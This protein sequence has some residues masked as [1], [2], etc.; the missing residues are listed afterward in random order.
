MK[1]SFY[2]PEANVRW[3]IGIYTGADWRRL[4][5]A[6]GLAHPVL[7]PE[8]VTDGRSRLVAD[9]F[10]VREEG[11]WYMFF[12]TLDPAVGRGE[13]AYATSADGLTWRYGGVVLREPFHLSY[14]RVFRWEGRY[15]M[16]P[17]TRQ[18][19]AVRL[20]TAV[21]F[22]TRWSFAGS[23]V[24]GYLADPTVLDHDGRFWLFAQRGLDEMRLYVA[25]R[26]VGPWREH[27]VSPVYVGDR[28]RSRP[29]GPVLADS[30]RLYRLAQDAIPHYG[31][32]IRAF[33]IER[34][35]ET[36]YREHPVDGGPVLTASRR[37]WNAMGMHHLDAHQTD[38]GNWLAA[39]DGA[40]LELA[41]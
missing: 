32:S 23:L 34:L 10:L 40:T 37:G 19:H 5:P 14:P 24:H 25:D 31:H 9:P 3:S 33:E 26:P 8:H 35:T 20:Y 39:V 1:G 41:Q 7:T 15:Y 30:G 13:I 6:P 18:A 28:S 29:A 2:R 27:P 12:E 38:T 22:P 16:T 36:E 17:E 11:G 4:E 21:D